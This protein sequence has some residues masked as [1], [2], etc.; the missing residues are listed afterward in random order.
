ALDDLACSTNDEKSVVPTGWTT[1]P[2]TRPPF[3]STVSPAYFTASAPKATSGRMKYQVLFCPPSISARGIAVA[4]A[5]TSCVQRTVLGEH[6]APVSARPPEL[7]GMRTMFA[8][9]AIWLIASEIEVLGM[10]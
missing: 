8:S 9:R 1:A 4:L 6:C 7:D 10:S 5:H 2:T 3:F